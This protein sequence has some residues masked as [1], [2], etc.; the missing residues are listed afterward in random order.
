MIRGPDNIDRFDRYRL[1]ENLAD[2]NLDNMTLDEQLE[3][4]SK[5]ISGITNLKEYI[6]KSDTSNKMWNEKLDYQI[7][8]Y[9]GLLV[10]LRKGD[11]KLL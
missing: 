5:K 3:F 1:Y 7:E 4:A 2:S 11:Y 10:Q 9:K 6:F 8:Y